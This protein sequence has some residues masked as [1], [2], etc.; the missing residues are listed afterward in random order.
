[1]QPGE[2]LQAELDN[3]FI[4]PSVVR[5]M[6]ELLYTASESGLI[7][8]RLRGE[9]VVVALKLAKLANNLLGV[10]NYLRM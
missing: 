9:D 10:P 2:A 7:D 1:M 3:I 4:A 5:H 6:E 8:Y